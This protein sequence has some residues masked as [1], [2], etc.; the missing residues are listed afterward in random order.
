[1]LSHYRRLSRSLS[2]DQQILGLSH[3]K[4]ETAE[5]RRVDKG[6]L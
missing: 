4:T 1:M 5:N 2:S 3:L 6:L